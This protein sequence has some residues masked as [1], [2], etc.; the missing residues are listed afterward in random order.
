MPRSSLFLP[1]S[2]VLCTVP[3][4]VCTVTA[5]ELAPITDSINTVN[6]AVMA[7]NTVRLKE[8]LSSGASAESKDDAGYTALMRA[9]A[10]GHTECVRILLEAGAKP[11]AEDDKNNRIAAYWAARN[12]HDDCLHL[13]LETAGDRQVQAQL[14]KGIFLSEETGNQYS[15]AAKF[16][17]MQLLSPEGFGND[18]E[19]RDCLFFSVKEGDKPALA[20]LRKAGGTLSPRENDR[21]LR[22]AAQYGWEDEVRQ[23]LEFYTDASEREWN[24]GD[25]LR[26]AVADGHADCAKILLEACKDT[27]LK[28]KCA[29]RA[30]APAAAGGCRECLELVL[31]AVS[32]DMPLRWRDFCP[33]E[34][35]YALMLAASHGDPACVRM[36][37]EAGCDANETTK[38]QKTALM[39]AAKEG[40]TD[41]VRLLLQAGADPD[42]RTCSNTTALMMAAEG[43]HTDCVKILLEAGADPTPIETS[44]KRSIL[45]C[46]ARSGNDECL[47]EV[48]KIRSRLKDTQTCLDRALASSVQ[49]SAGVQMLL[50]AGADANGRSY[51][52]ETALMHAASCGNREGVGILLKAGADVNTKVEYSGTALRQAAREGKTEMMLLLLRSGAKADEWALYQAGMYARD[53]MFRKEETAAFPAAKRRQQY[54]EADNRVI[55]EMLRILLQSGADVRSPGGSAALLKLAEYKNTEGIR[56]LLE[57]GAK[58]DADFGNCLSPLLF[59]AENE[60]SVAVRLLVQAGADPNICNS[61]AETPLMLC[62][63]AGDAPAVQ[64]LLKAGAKWDIRNHHNHTALDMAEEAGQLHCAR[65]LRNAGATPSPREEPE[66]EDENVELEKLVKSVTRA[67]GDVNARDEEYGETALIKAAE[68]GRLDCI[69]QLLAAGAEV[70][71]RDNGRETALMAAAW[72]G[73][74]DCVRLLL[75]AGADVNARDIDGRTPLIIH[76]YSVVMTAEDA[77]QVC[78]LLLKAG[79][80][81]DACNHEGKTALMEAAS[82]GLTDSVK[83]LL[84]AGAEVE[85]RDWDGETPLMQAAG[86]N[87]LDCLKL[88][89]AAGA[90][91]EARNAKGGTALIAAATSLGM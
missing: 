23:C 22:A 52:G 59:A 45:D 84:A 21:L 27:D 58:A 73:H 55:V 79:A 43:G 19:L 34:D 75:E 49:T 26:A 33:R 6:A 90:N 17:D 70:D 53:W 42:I 82:C 8:L 11:N 10:C 39:K 30:I 46:A 56:L 41:C 54:I 24:A 85:A 63:R 3:A 89:L 31:G 65:L 12:G 5:V 91:V 20:L 74:A 67:G 47:A 28:D 60:D 13:L 68:L 25:A 72:N 66:N 61:N 71:A 29:R 32:K 35:N 9:A 37:L 2:A 86:R 87:H 51:F 80:K 62:A 48:L 16:M 4:C 1:L 88:L 78:G 76:N 38:E 7:N 15:M 64:A 18:E 69:K 57:A 14:A 44:S 81:I 77:A 36:L 40:H 50:E 83:L